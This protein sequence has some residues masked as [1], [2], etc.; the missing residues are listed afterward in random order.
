MWLYKAHLCG[1]S[2]E[3][4]APGLPR[5]KNV[6]LSTYPSLFEAYGLPLIEAQKLGLPVIAAELDYVRDLIDP[7]ESFNPLSPRS[8]SRSVKR[9]LNIKEKRPP[10]LTSE[11]LFKAIVE[12]E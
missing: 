6:T 5:T 12:E 3:A 9:F 11:N 2:N 10:I 8:I 7:V 4:Q 1:Q